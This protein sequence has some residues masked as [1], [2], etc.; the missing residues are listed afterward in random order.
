M[1]NRFVEKVISYELDR[2]AF[3]HPLLDVRP[4]PVSP[5]SFAD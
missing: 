5:P 4:L 3:E 2:R 1:Y